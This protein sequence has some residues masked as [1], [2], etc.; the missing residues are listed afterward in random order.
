L[1]DNGTQAETV[2][3]RG[4]LDV[5]I[6]EELVEQARA[7]GLALTGPDGL[8]AQIT[9]NVIQ[10]ALEAEMTEHLGFAKGDRAASAATG[11]SNHRNGTSK[12]TVQTGVGPVE[13]DIPCDRASESSP[14]TPGA[15]VASTRPWSRST[16]RA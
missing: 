14:S 4:G 9:T 6:A 16:P 10:A 11:S 15:S 1:N 7:E 13:L 8:L 3:S 5:R 2:A 12:K